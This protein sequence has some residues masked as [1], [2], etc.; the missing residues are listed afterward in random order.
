M[1]VSAENSI[2]TCPSCSGAIDGT[3]IE[4][5]SLIVCPHCSQEFPVTQKFGNYRLE[6]KLGSGGMGAVYLATDL[7]LGR[8]V[9]IKVLKKELTED[10]KF[11]ETFKR[12]AEITAS[13]NHPNVVQVYAAGEVNGVYYLAMEC[14]TGGSLDDRIVEFGRVT[15]LEGLEVGIAVASGLLA[16][17]E[18][19]LVH[20]D[21]KPG[22]ILYG[23]NLTPKVVDFGL[24]LDRTTQDQFAGEIWGTP[25]YLPPEKLEGLPED[26]RSDLYSLGA[27]LF[28]AMSGRPP[29]EHEDPRE[30][31]MM[32][33]KGLSVSL[34]TFVPEV[35]MQTSNA[36]SR[37][38]AR[39]PNDRFQS[40]EEFIS[41]MEDSKRRVLTGD[42]THKHEVPVQVITNPETSGSFIWIVGGVV[43]LILL[44]LVALFFFKD[45]IFSG[46]KM[47]PTELENYDPSADAPAKPVK[48]K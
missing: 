10:V 7:L 38:M 1:E 20:R 5:G 21:I 25:Y 44:L 16:A 29:Y 27:T 14:I 42:P 31:A 34:K 8:Q 48:K 18:R 3:G 30:V 13:L 6:K 11:L 24:A 35:Q 47:V 23:P 43:L 12:E 41:Q 46:K 33:L 9:A 39:Y 15:E 40:Y 26:F 45:A 36:I 2:L 37:A 28:H 4:I 17:Q 22:N 19:G 32:H